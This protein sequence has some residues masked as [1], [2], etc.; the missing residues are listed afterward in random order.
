MF[1]GITALLLVLVLVVAGAKAYQRRNEKKQ[2]EAIRGRWGKEKE[3]SRPFEKIALYH[4]YQQAL[5]AAPEAFLSKQTAGDLNMKQV[6]ARVDRCYTTVGEQYLYHLLHSPGHESTVPEEREQYL[7][8]FKQEEKVREAVAAELSQLSSKLSYALPNLM[9]HWDLKPGKWSAFYKVLGVVP[10][11]WLGLSFIEPAFLFLLFA[12]FIVN[13]FVH[14]AQKKRLDFFLDP[15]TQLI[16]MRRS[17]QRLAGIHSLLHKEEVMT[18][19]KQLEPISSYYGLLVSGKSDQNELVALF[20]LVLEYLKIT[21][22]LEVNVLDRCITLLASRKEATHQLY[23]FIG[24]TDALLSVASFRE[25]LP[26]YCRPLFTAGSEACL[27]VEEVYHPLVESCKPNSLSLKGEGAVITGSNMSG[28]TTFIRTLSLNA[29]LAQTINTVLA[30][31]YKATMFAISTSISIKDDLSRGSSYY[32]EEIESVHVL[33]KQSRTSAL[34]QLLVIDELFKGTNTTE[35]I[36]A[37]RAVLLYLCQPATMVL[38]STHDLELARL[39][40][41]S[42]RQY[43]FTE[44]IR[45]GALHFDHK[46][47]EGP[48]QSRN[49]IRLLELVGYPELVVKN[50]QEY[51]GLLAGESGNAVAQGK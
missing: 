28:K 47:K 42:Y 33:L 22:L 29:L 19:C 24:E 13:V 2:Q 27:E 4:Q 38:V 48:L 9:H 18:A 32:L 39:L 50:A 5:A 44:T 1:A 20:T 10:M 8:C 40:K 17:S 51:A 7:R 25:E 34:P 36:A 11:L 31:S 6:F 45:D 14:Y 26:Y 16:L 15:F 46:L 21:F 37:A 30:R 23:S 49:A 43:H 41:E 12:N 3:A 35:R